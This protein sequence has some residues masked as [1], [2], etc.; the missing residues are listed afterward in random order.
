MPFLYL[1]RYHFVIQEIFLCG[2][3][4]RP[5]HREIHKTALGATESV[6]WTYF[7]SIEKAV[8]KVEAEKNEVEKVAVIKQTT[9]AKV[10]Q[11][12]SKTDA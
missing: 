2:I 5:P 6:N 7:E 4:A 10:K 9:A 3:T 1:L 12:N 8:E 11:E